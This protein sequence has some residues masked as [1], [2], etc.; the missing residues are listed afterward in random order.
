MRDKNR[1]VLGV[2]G[3]SQA[4]AYQS[5]LLSRLQKLLDQVLQLLSFQVTTSCKDKEAPRY[6]ISV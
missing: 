6:Q 5:S 2:K 1:Y 4:Q 3:L